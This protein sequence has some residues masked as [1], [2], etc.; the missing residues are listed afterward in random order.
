MGDIECR[1]VSGDEMIHEIEQTI[2]RQKEN[3]YAFQTG[4]KDVDFD[5]NYALVESLGLSLPLRSLDQ[6]EQ[7]LTQGA[8]SPARFFEYDGAEHMVMQFDPNPVGYSGFMDCVTHS[9]A[10]TDKGLFEVGRYPAASMSNPGRT[11]QWFLHRRLATPEEV[12][13]ILEEKNWDRTEFMRRVY[14]ALTGID[15]SE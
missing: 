6:A 3:K 10:M 9:L 7:A 13:S 8:I 14:T 12:H 2:Q 4:L 15:R 5:I 11:W 1:A